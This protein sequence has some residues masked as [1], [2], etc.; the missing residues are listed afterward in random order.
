MILPGAAQPLPVLPAL[1]SSEYPPVLFADSPP[2]FPPGA[3]VVRPDARV[4]LEPHHLDSER[5]PRGAGCSKEARDPPGGE[6]NKG[7]TLRLPRVYE[8]ERESV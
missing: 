7:E 6:R 8:H 4:Q 5:R 2:I 1:C 3:R